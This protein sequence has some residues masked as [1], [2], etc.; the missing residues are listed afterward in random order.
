MQNFSPQFWP[1]LP[2]RWLTKELA[3]NFQIID[4]LSQPRSFRSKYLTCQYPK[5]TWLCTEKQA[6]HRPCHPRLRAARLY[7]TSY[8]GLNIRIPYI[9]DCA[10]TSQFCLIFQ[11]LSFKNI[12]CW[13]KVLYYVIGVLIQESKRN[14]VKAYCLYRNVL[15]I[16][17]SLLFIYLATKIFFYWILTLWAFCNLEY[18]SKSAG[19]Y[20]PSPFVN[21]K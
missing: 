18:V 4:L 15:D 21:A 20:I 19:V 1:S 14:L 6:R 17:E 10:L 3:P 2:F 11:I 9:E 16:N 13:E 7:A 12:F 8:P 5:L